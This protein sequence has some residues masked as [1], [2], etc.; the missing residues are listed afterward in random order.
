MRAPRL[1]ELVIKCLRSTINDPSIIARWASIYREQKL[2]NQPEVLAEAKRLDADILS[3]AKTISN[4]VGRVSDLPPEISADL[5]YDQI[6]SLTVKKERLTLAKEKIKTQVQDLGGRDI[7]ETALT[8]R[9]QRAV[10][11][12]ESVPKE[13]Q[14]RILRELIH[15]IEI[16]PTK[17][18]IGL[19]SPI[20]PRDA[21]NTGPE[22][23]KATGTDGLAAKSN[24]RTNYR[25]RLL[26]A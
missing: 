6:K 11:R 3:I 19:Y 10:S 22:T 20:K 15:N 7:D 14:R 1:E 5:F 8:E 13:A 16:H 18:K 26:N 12:L 24:F 17:L 23:Q 4:L 25:L 2:S 21:N 9:I